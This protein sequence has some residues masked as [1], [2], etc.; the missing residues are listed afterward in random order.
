MPQMSFRFF[1]I[2]KGFEIARLASILF[3]VARTL[4]FRHA[5]APNRRSSEIWKK[6]LSP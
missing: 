1:A 2:A 4:D 3:L 5:S 6:I